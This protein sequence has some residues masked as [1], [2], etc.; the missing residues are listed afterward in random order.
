M[1]VKP[2]NRHHYTTPEYKAAREVVRKRA[3][4][5]CECDGLCGLKHEQ[6]FAGRCC[7]PNRTRVL[8]DPTEPSRWWSVE[9]GYPCSLIDDGVEFVMVTLTTAHLDHDAGTN[10]PARMRHLCNLCHLRYDAAHHAETAKATRARKREA[11]AVEAGQKALA[12]GGSR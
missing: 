10:D 7:A 12:L 6:P 9:T 5:R 4:G 3:G 11:A 1:P 2:E 8:R